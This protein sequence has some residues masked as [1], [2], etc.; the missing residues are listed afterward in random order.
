MRRM[1]LFC[2]VSMS[3]ATCFAAA[4]PVRME[5]TIDGV[6]REAAVFYPAEAVTGPRPL[7][8]VFHGH[9]GSMRTAASSFD[10]PTRWP[11]AIAVYLQGLPTPIRLTDPEGKK[12]AGS[13][14]PASTATATS[15]SS[16]RCSLP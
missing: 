2:L 11:E 14:K 8:L 6:E 12:R 5:F 4:A 16:T 9:G 1:F 13:G 7:V 3:A 10:F 15:R